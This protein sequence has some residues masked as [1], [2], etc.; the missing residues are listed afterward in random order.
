[1]TEAEGHDG[2]GYDPL[3]FLPELGKTMAQLTRKE[4][5]EVSHRGRAL[6]ALKEGHWRKMRA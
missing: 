3:F 4:K 6:K 2:F 5:N 1:L